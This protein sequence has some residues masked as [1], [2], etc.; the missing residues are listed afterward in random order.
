MKSALKCFLIE[1]RKIDSIGLEF[2]IL[3]LSVISHLFGVISLESWFTWFEFWIIVGG[4]N[5]YN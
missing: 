4:E 3:D 1:Y 5:S 2:E